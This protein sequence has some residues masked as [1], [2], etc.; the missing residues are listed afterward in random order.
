MTEA[1]SKQTMESFQKNFNDADEIR[2]MDKARVEVL[3]L[4]SQQVMR[5]TFEPGWKWSECLKPIAGTESCQVAH[6]GY[7]VTGHM[8]VKMDDGTEYELKA[9]DVGVIPPGHDAWIVGDESAVFIDFQGAANYA[10][11]QS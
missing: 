11:P 8:M 7:M 10:K 1:A 2:T 6:T 3:D 9:G 4:G 5:G